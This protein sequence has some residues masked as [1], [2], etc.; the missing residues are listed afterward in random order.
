M[1]SASME[2]SIR[3][4]EVWRLRRTYDA[5]RRDTTASLSEKDGWHLIDAYMVFFVAGNDIRLYTTAQVHRMVAD[6]PEIWDY[7][8]HVHSLTREVQKIVAPGLKEF[9]FPEVLA[10]I[11]MVHDRLG[12]EIDDKI[13]KDV[14][15]K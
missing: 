12:S 8:I 6:A 1:I 9:T 2:A 14:E 10:I 15:S 11:E 4:E 13:C 7:W 5:L 3:G